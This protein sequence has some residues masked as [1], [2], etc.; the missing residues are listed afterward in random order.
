MRSVAR[1]YFSFPG[2]CDDSYNSEKYCIK[3]RIHSSV[4]IVKW[5][6]TRYS[7]HSATWKKKNA[8]WMSRVW[9]IQAVNSFHGDEL[10]F[11]QACFFFD[12]ICEFFNFLWT[13]VGR[14]DERSFLTASETF[15]ICFIS[16]TK[17]W[18]YT[19]NIYVYIQVCPC[20]NASNGQK[21]E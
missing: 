10:K 4:I 13:S 15:P 18:S 16:Q 9:F 8:V 7:T 12:M 14:K 21:W 17:V 11:M 19:C 2:K 1:E 6:K 5:Q 20:V 3:H